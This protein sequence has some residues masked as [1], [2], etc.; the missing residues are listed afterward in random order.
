MEQTTPCIARASPMH[1]VRACVRRVRAR[2]CGACACAAC[3]RACV[4]RVRARACGA[5]ACAGGLAH[6]AVGDHTLETYDEHVGVI[7]GAR[8]GEVGV[9]VLALHRGHEGLKEFRE[10]QH[11]ARAML[12]PHCKQVAP[13]PPRM[14]HLCNEARQGRPKERQGA[15]VGRNTGLYSGC[16]GRSVRTCPCQ[17][18][19]SPLPQEEIE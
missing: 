15:D 7:E 4:R 16:A 9:I 18:C 19:G 12:V 6:D 8:P 10:P 3:A 17:R 2:V 5:C 13:R 11:I 14:A 1:V